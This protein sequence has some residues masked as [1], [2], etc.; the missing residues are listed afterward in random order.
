MPRSNGNI[1]QRENFDDV[2]DLLK[3]GKYLT[4]I[5]K[6]KGCRHSVIQRYCNRNSIDYGKKNPIFKTLDGQT[7]DNYTIIGLN[8]TFDA[9]EKIW[10][11]QCN[12]GKIFKIRSSRINNTPSCG[13]SDSLI[14]PKFVKE[15]KDVP[16]WFW[17]K[18]IDG[19]V[20]RNNIPFSIS[21]EELWDIYIQQN[22]KCIYTGIILFIPTQKT[23]FTFNAS[24][25]RID[26]KIG[27]VSGNVQWV[28]KKI[29]M[30]KGVLSS[31]D[32]VEFC[33]LVANNR[34]NI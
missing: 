12:C 23:Q 3:S 21:K 25:D 30:M 17:N 33:M 18:F 14:A 8:S 10:D 27:Y 19:A 6:E 11:A 15:F 1:K 4:E 31:E 9:G 28:H 29:N 26:S 22:K 5:A 7:F 13:C 20:K 34:T 2:E 32:F 16:A 24:I